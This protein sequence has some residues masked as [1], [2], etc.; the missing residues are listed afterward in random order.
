MNNLFRASLLGFYKIIYIFLSQEWHLKSTS[1]IQIDDENSLELP[2]ELSCT[3][4]CRKHIP[5]TSLSVHPLIRCEHMYV[6]TYL[7]NKGHFNNSTK[8]AQTPGSCLEYILSGEFI[9]SLI[10]IK[11]NININSARLPP[12]PTAAERY[13]CCFDTQKKSLFWNFHIVRWCLYLLIIFF[14]VFV[15]FLFIFGPCFLFHFSASF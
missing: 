12:P 4:V 1:L 3:T 13:A 2:S 9:R 5:C 14:V 8:T 10:E 15:L 6:H 11:I 7:P